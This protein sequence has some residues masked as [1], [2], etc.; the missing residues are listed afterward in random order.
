MLGRVHPGNCSGQFWVLFLMI[1]KFG[2]NCCLWILLCWRSRDIDVAVTDVFTAKNLE[3]LDSTD[4]Y[5][6]TEYAER[7]D[8]LVGRASYRARLE[9]TMTSNHPF[10]WV[11]V[12]VLVSYHVKFICKCLGCG[13]FQW[14]F[15]SSVGAYDSRN[16]S[17]SHLAVARVSELY[18]FLS[19]L[20]QVSDC[21][22][23]LR[24]S[25]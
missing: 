12:E 13:C 1:L 22:N 5:I 7:Y 4:L 8:L 2:D 9:F 15:V 20:A 19:C 17:D 18:A 23:L 25:V 16:C 11:E 21:V 24:T 10:F 6:A 3:K 14:G